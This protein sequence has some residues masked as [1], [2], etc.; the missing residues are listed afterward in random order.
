MTDILHIVN[1]R[2]VL[3]KNVILDGINLT[4][5][6]GELCVLLGRNGVGKSSLFKC[7]LGAYKLDE[8]EILI[9]GENVIGRNS[10]H[11]IGVLL[12]GAALYE[13]LDAYTNLDIIRRYYGLPANVIEETLDLV[14]LS[15]VGNKKT[16]YFSSGMKQRLGLAAAIMHRPPFILLDEPMNMLDIEGKNEFN[17]LIDQ[18]HKTYNI[19]F[20]LST[21]DLADV[22]KQSWRI[23]ILKDTQIVFDTATQQID[24]LRIVSES[25]RIT[26]S[27]PDPMYSLTTEGRKRFIYAHGMIRT[28]YEAK[29]DEIPTIEELYLSV[30]GRTV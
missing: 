24:S 25:D 17:N 26:Y 19:T 14:G 6:A 16:R 22:K 4:L 27:L 9:D 8:G 20:L 29:F 11:K 28:Y 2:L 15:E 12:E 13:H 1:A 5:K 21:H 30:Y 18:L 7:I 3:S 23:I 10:L